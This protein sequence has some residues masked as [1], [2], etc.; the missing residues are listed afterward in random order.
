MDLLRLHPVGWA[1]LELAEL[2]SVEV[3][4]LY[5]VELT[6]VKLAGLWPVEVAGLYPVEQAG[7]PK[8]KVIAAGIR[9]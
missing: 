9:R 6:G 7:L 5:P 8:W 3:T 2:Y 4:G 1:G